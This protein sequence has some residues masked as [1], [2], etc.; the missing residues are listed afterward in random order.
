MIVNEHRLSL[1]LVFFFNLKSMKPKLPRRCQ[2]QMRTTPLTSK[3]R[4]EEKKE[5]DEEEE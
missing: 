2:R 1:L 5:E 4:S 3:D